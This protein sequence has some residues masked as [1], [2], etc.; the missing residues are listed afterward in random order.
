L[1]NVV[2]KRHSQIEQAFPVPTKETDDN[3][4]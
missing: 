4:A 3:D 2:C 1:T